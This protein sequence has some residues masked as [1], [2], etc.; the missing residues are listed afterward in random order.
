MIRNAVIAALAVALAL[1]IAGVVAQVQRTSTVEV[2][3]WEDVEDPAAHLVTSRV[4][5]GEWRE[6]V[7]LTGPYDGYV[8]GGRFWYR[9]FYVN[10]IEP[11]PI[12]P[13]VE[14]FDLTCAPHVHGRTSHL[15]LRGSLRNATDATLGEVTITAARL[16]EDGVEVAQETGTVEGG[17]SPGGVREF[18]VNFF[19][20]P[21][22]TGSCVI[23]RVEYTGWW[24]VGGD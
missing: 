4:A 23:L 18:T 13:A 24:V 11:E 21:G 8:Q 12:P 7:A 9:D 1:S 2:R 20:S 17:I 14:L 19:G 22:V 3:I 15:I 10:A 6:A 5:G 16:E